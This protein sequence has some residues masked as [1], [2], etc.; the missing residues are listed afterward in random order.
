VDKLN[1]ELRIKNAVWAYRQ[2][3]INIFQYFDLI[4]HLLT[5]IVIINVMGCAKG[6]SDPAPS[7][8]KNPVISCAELAGTY[9]NAYVS[10]SVLTLTNYC[11]LT[12]TSC[13]YVGSFT[14]PKIADGST[15]LTIDMSHGGLCMGT[16]VHSC[17]IELKGI[18]LG[19]TCDDDTQ[20]AVFNKR[21]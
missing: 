16:S 15:S 8:P 17:R 19:I 1:R 6:S 12:E 2:G 4:R 18:Q 13:G 7:T 21:P 20:T 9:D 5:I 14:Q 10:G 3:H 11:N